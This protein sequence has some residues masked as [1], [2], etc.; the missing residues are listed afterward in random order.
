MKNEELKSKKLEAGKKRSSFRDKFC[1][2]L[3]TFHYLC[4]WMDGMLKIVRNDFS[5]FFI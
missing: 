3:F 5:A 2:A 4:P 1:F